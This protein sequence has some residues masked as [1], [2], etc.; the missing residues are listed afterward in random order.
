[1]RENATLR[2]VWARAFTRLGVCVRHDALVVCD[3]ET[4]LESAS[5]LARAND[6][7][8]PL[9][10]VMDAVRGWRVPLRVRYHP[11]CT[12][13]YRICSRTFRWACCHG[14]LTVAVWLHS[15]RGK[16][17]S[18]SDE[19]FVD[20]GARENVASAFELTCEKGHLDVA[21]WLEGLRGEGGERVVDVGVLEEWGFRMACGNG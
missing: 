20:V 9:H 15:L 7:V 1:M 16:K 17:G 11:P 19:R 12:S 21:V 2:H 5:R 10:R 13:L 18:E 8:S 6:D 4:A 14:H 3:L